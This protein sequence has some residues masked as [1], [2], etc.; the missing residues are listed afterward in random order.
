MRKM[1]RRIAGNV[2]ILMFFA[3]V[4]SPA[5]FSARADKIVDNSDSVETMKSANIPADIVK[6]KMEYKVEAPQVEIESESV[7]YEIKSLD[8]ICSCKAGDYISFGKYEQDGNAENGRE[9]I[10]WK[11]LKVES[12]RILVVSKYALDC[13]PYNT[14]EG[15]VTWETSSLR[16]WLN[17][18]FK[19]DA[20][21]AEDQEK[22]PTVT[23]ANESNSY[24]GT[25]GG[26]DTQ[27]QI[28]CL[29]LSEIEGLI[30]YSWY[31]DEMMYGYSQEMVVEPTA[32]AIGKGAYSYKITEENAALLKEYGFDDSINGCRGCWWWLRSPGFDN[33]NACSVYSTGLAGNTHSM[34]ASYDNVAVL[35]ALYIS[36]P[37][38]EPEIVDEN[39][40]LDVPPM[41]ETEPSVVPE[42][43]YDVEVPDDKNAISVVSDDVDTDVNVSEENGKDTDVIADET[44]TDSEDVIDDNKD[45]GEDVINSDS[46]NIDTDVADD[47]ADA[48]ET[49]AANTDNVDADV[50]TAED[51]ADEDT[52]IDATEPEAEEDKI[53]DEGN[54]AI[55]EEPT[56]DFSDEDV[57]LEDETSDENTEESAE[58]DPDEGEEP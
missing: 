57:I 34:I 54:D 45:N 39:E 43:G 1:N 14:E 8:A 16:D 31:D 15:E 6:E 49:D 37:G 23:V 27:D 44:D 29:S 7:S 19:N 30:G 25:S 55:V 41:E 17:N 46:A 38:I 52:L 24:Y 21:S 28:F 10:A 4:F 11:V 3:N 2:L 56:A 18:D 32:Y 36:V 20:F 51:N 47:S 13:V 22:I 9:D 53:D 40:E 42:V 5:S 50:D 33:G 48:E 12:D 26:N 58:A 35:P